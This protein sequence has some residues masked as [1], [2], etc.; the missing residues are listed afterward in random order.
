[1]IKT[2]T[3]NA[4]IEKRIRGKYI[5]EVQFDIQSTT[6]NAAGIGLKVTQYLKQFNI[7]SHAYVM[8]ST[9][10]ISLIQ[11]MFQDKEIASTLLENNTRLKVNTIYIDE[12]ENTQRHQEHVAVKDDYVIL[13][14]SV[15]EKDITS[16]DVVVFEYNEDSIS[17]ERMK[18]FYTTIATTSKIQILDI[19]P[20]YWDMLK[21][22][23]VDVLVMDEKQCLTKMKKERVA[24]SAM[25]SYIKSEIVPKAKVVVYTLHCNDILLFVDGKVL[26]VTCAIKQPHR[27]CYK[28]AILS[29]IVKCYVEDGDLQKLAEECM[30]MSV[31]ASISEGLFIP[32]E[33]LVDT[34]KEKVMLYSLLG[35]E[36]IYEREKCL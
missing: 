1:M 20:K 12:E 33:T 8:G 18:K 2:F 17:K 13:F 4:G 19:H 5:D 30:A 31:G 22:R 14:Q 24:L 16:E 11:K 15:V 29:G 10:A 9:P 7:P 28:E 27:Q 35:K 36:D 23:Q 3:L 26:R 32:Q 34:I 25:I 21:E 6:Q